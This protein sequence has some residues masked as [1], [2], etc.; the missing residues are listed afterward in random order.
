MKEL[1]TLILICGF[2]FLCGIGIG[3]AIN[4]AMNRWKEGKRDEMDAG[5]G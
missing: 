2:T 4:E 3:A 1:M 5:R